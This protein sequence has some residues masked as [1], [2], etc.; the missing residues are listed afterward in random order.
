MSDTPPNR[1]LGATESSSQPLGESP[2]KDN[3]TPIHPQVKETFLTPLKRQYTFRL[4]GQMLLALEDYAR[5]NNLTVPAA[6][7][8]LVEFRLV[9]TGHLPDWW[10]SRGKLRR[11]G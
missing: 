7:R 8:D 1:T 6:L 11:K 2:S 10:L 4:Q 3:D 5:E 9:Q